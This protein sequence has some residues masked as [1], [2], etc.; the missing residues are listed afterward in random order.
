MRPQKRVSRK[1]ALFSFSI[2]LLNTGVFLL[3]QQG[4][5]ITGDHA[6][7]KGAGLDRNPSSDYPQVKF[8]D[9]TQEAGIRFEHFHG[10]RSTQL[11]ED[12]GSGAAWS[13]HQS[14][15]RDKGDVLVRPC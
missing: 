3:A 8:T 4:T 12:I 13:A 10:V 6:A 7:H 15:D 2:A 11:P 1:Y 5:D 14:A 9:V